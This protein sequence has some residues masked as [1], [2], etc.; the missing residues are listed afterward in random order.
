M[1]K[2]STCW[3]LLIKCEHTHFSSSR[4]RIWAQCWCL[5]TRL[6]AQKWALGPF[7]HTIFVSFGRSTALFSL[8][9]SCFKMASNR[10]KWSNY[11][12]SHILGNQS[13]NTTP[14]CAG[15]QALVPVHCVD[16]PLEFMLSSVPHP[17]YSV[18]TGMICV[19]QKGGGGGGGDWLILWGV[20]LN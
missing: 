6:R 4:A 2:Y 9:S 18:G 17:C 3:A 14:F 7:V 12:H 10:V 19:Y 15:T 20:L 11:K 13:V 16:S 1:P 5:S 8:L